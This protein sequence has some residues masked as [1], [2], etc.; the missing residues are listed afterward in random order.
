[1]VLATPTSSVSQLTRDP[2]VAQ[3]SD[4]F[5]L[6]ASPIISVTKYLQTIVIPWG[7]SHGNRHISR[8]STL[9]FIHV[10]YAAFSFAIC[11]MPYR[12][13]PIFAF[14]FSVPLHSRLMHHASHVDHER[15]GEIMASFAFDRLIPIALL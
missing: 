8:F 11:I 9:S 5:H 12:Q 6:N 13:S 10:H 15:Y 7:T 4:S 3:F 1:M 2:R 14:P